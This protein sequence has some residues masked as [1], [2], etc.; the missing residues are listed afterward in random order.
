MLRR[1]AAADHLL[2]VGDVPQ[3]RRRVDAVD[4]VARERRVRAGEGKALQRV[5]G[6]GE[7]E[8]DGRNPEGS[9]PRAFARRA[10]AIT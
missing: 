1:G 10:V 6:R 8:A 2:V 5:R 4:G 7:G 9:G 3:T